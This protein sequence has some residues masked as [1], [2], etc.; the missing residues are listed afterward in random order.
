MAAN[1]FLSGFR[2]DAQAGIAEPLGAVQLMLGEAMATQC[3]EPSFV[4]NHHSFRCFSR[5]RPG[6]FALL[7]AQES[8]AVGACILWR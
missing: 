7:V 3:L 8:E 6:P 2:R 4:T 5:A 1:C